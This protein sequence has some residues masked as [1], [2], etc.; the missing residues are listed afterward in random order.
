LLVHLVEPKPADQTDPIE[1]YRSIR[2]ELREYDPSLGMRDEIVVISKAELGDTDEVR[3]ALQA[4]SDRE[5][6]VI[7]AVTG[8]GL[9]RLTEEIMRR[10]QIRHAELLASGE[11]VTTSRETQGASTTEQRAKRLPPH[12]SGPTAALS[13]DMQAK[14]FHEDS[15]EAGGNEEST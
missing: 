14:D 5:V 12:L 13:D 11:E 1:N 4:E 6:Y 2:N 3:Q 10:V 7:S 8:D 9:G 15:V